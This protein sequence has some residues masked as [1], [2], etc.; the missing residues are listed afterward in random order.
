[1]SNELKLTD[2]EVA[3]LMENPRLAEMLWPDSEKL[4]ADGTPVGG[5]AGKQLNGIDAARSC[6]DAGAPW[7]DAVAL[8]HAVATFFSESLLYTE[9]FHHNLDV[10]GNVVSTDWGPCQLNDKAHPNFFPNGDHMVIAC[11]PARCFGAAFEVFQASSGS[12]DPW[13]GWKNG[14]ALDD[15]YLRR[16]A[17]AVL[18]L[19]AAN[20]VGLA[21]ARDPVIAGRSTPPTKT[22]V[23]MINTHELAR[24]Y[25][26]GT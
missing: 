23:P 26:P 9:A 24:V 4:T 5:L 22:R 18:N 2:D 11:N 21:N 7:R 8:S 13:F 10:D 15:Y 19:V 6:F 16:G 1:M 14:V 3:V 20:M 25:P 17:L 12:L